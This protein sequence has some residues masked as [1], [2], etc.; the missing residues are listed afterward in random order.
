MMSVGD[1]FYP[2]ESAMEPIVVEPVES[3]VESVVVLISR[4]FRLW[5]LC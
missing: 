4:L 2:I 1:I 3:A 5:G